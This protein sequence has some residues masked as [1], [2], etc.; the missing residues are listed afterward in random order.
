MYAFYNY[1]SEKERIPNLCGSFQNPEIWGCSAAL[2][3]YVRIVMSKKFDD[4]KEFSIPWVCML[5]PFKSRPLDSE[6]SIVRIVYNNI[7]DMI[8]NIQREFE[9][10][11]MRGY[12]PK[13]LFREPPSYFSILSELPYVK[14]YKEKK[15][16]NHNFG[17]LL[18]YIYYS[19]L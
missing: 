16:C 11:K 19:C 9:I 6:G 14:S 17:Y 7:R 12:F 18:F 3:E 5:C 13:E 15:D 4:L 8:I 10:K 1:I 2:A